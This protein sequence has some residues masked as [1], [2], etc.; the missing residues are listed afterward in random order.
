MATVIRHIARRTVTGGVVI[1]SMLCAFL[2]Q[3]AGQIVQPGSPFLTNP[4][5]AASWAIGPTGSAVPANG[6][7]LGASSGGNLVGVV[8]CDSYVFKHVTS[9]TDT[10]AVQGVSSQTIKVCGYKYNFSGSAAQSVFLENT[11]STNAN[12]SSANTQISALVTGNS[13]SP[14]TNGFHNALWSGLRNTSGNG[15][16]INS[17]GTGGVD[18]EIWYT[19]GS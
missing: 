3:S 14:S 18:V 5:T 10:L 1:A 2:T 19:Q 11:A 8:L 7:Y 16:C 15:L 12:C 13:S 9:A 17:S 6:H 4:G